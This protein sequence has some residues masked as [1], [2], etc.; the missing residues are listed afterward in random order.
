MNFH[1]GMKSFPSLVKC[2]LLF[3]CFSRDE[4]LSQ[5]KFIPVKNREMKFHFAII[6]NTKRR[7]NILLRDG[8]L[9]WACFYLI[10][11]VRDQYAF[12]MLEI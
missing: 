1:P 11:D 6:K 12:H 7:V 4:I 8:N 10:F 3:I 5:N 9:K 2:L